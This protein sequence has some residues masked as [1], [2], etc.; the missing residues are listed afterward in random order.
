MKSKQD[1]KQSFS[2]PQGTVPS[3]YNRW[4]STVLLLLLVL[5]MPVLVH[6][7]E[8][9]VKSM[10]LV[11]E[12]ATANLTENLRTDNNGDYAGL[13]K[14]YLAAP[15]AQFFGPSVLGQQA[16]NA[17]EYWVFMAKEA[18]KLQVKVPGYLPLDVN[19]LDYGIEGVE[20]RRTYVLAILLPKVGNDVSKD[21][22]SAELDNASNSDKEVFTIKGVSFTMVRVEGGTFTMGATAEQGGDIYGN[23]KPA[24]EV[25]LR[26]YMIG[27]TEVTYALWEAVMG[28][29]FPSLIPQKPIDLVSWDKCHEFIKNLSLYTGRTFRLPTEAE[30]EYAARGGR[31][32]KHYKY[33]GSNTYSEVAW[34][35]ENSGDNPLSGEWE[36]DKLN[37][38]NCATHSV[39]GKA[40]NELGLY[41]MSGNVWEWCEDWYDSYYYE[42]SPR[43]YPKGPATGTE[44]VI[45]GGSYCDDSRNCRVSARDYEKPDGLSICVGFRLAL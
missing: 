35:W 20:S 22:N 11:P 10:Q 21:A 14:V 29:P 43:F 13:V 24:H 31:K 4:W 38:N 17:S 3:Y 39:K 41:D 23:E 6:A 15:G 19:F 25:S 36:L 26:S 44:R 28:A 18:F 27:E 9:T 1:I 5:S 40:P 37:N 34:M 33:S 2:L 32:S 30:W 45:R 42:S 7:Q 8:M 12:D 16:I